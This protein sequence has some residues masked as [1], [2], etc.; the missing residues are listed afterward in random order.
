MPPKLSKKQKKAQDFRKK[1]KDKALS[2]ENAVPEVDVVADQPESTRIDEKKKRK[3]EDMEDKEQSKDQE[4][5]QPKKKSRNRR[6]KKNNNN[7]EKKNRFI[8]FV[9]NL[10]F[11]TKAEDLAKHFES[12]GELPTVRLMTDKQTKKPK[13]FAFI[14]FQDSHHLSKALAF[15]HTFFNKRQINVELTAGGGGRSDARKEKLKEKNEKLQ[16]ERVSQ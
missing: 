1:Q 9:G 6:P 7:G 15:H 8:L 3:A 5:E 13:G 4:E 14:E 12:V 16:L 2:E 10:K 11:D